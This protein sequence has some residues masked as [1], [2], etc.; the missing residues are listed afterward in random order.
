MRLK[1]DLPEGPLAFKV[2]RCFQDVDGRYWYDSSN[3]AISVEYGPELIYL[4]TVRRGRVRFGA[5][6]GH[7]SPVQLRKAAI[8]LSEVGLGGWVVPG[9]LDVRGFHA[10]SPRPQPK[11]LAAIDRLIVDWE[12][13]GIRSVKLPP[14]RWRASHG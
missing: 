1:R 14:Y 2:Q 10:R 13:R 8:R 12:K 5:F 7:L 4:F 9:L 11:M 3:Y 6:P